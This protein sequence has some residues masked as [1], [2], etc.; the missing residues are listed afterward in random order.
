MTTEVDG[1][2]EILVEL[3]ETKYDALIEGNNRCRSIAD[4]KRLDSLEKS[5]RQDLS[6]LEG[7]LDAWAKNLDTENVRGRLLI[8]SQQLKDISDVFEI[9]TLVRGC[10]DSP[11]LVLEAAE[12]AKQLVISNEDGMLLVLLKNIAD[13][14]WEVNDHLRSVINHQT[15]LANCYSARVLMHKLVAT[16]LSANQTVDEPQFQSINSVDISQ[17]YL[18]S[19]SSVHSSSGDGA[20][21][22]FRNHVTT[23]LDRISRYQ[24]LCQNTSQYRTASGSTTKTVRQHTAA[25]LGHQVSPCLRKSADKSATQPGSIPLGSSSQVSGDYRA[26]MAEQYVAST[27]SSLEVQ[28]FA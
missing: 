24:A 25:W 27:R 14:M 16:L 3:L 20:V 9:P 6:Q 22:D 19:P 1:V 4:D 8:P 15:P 28:K 18:S 2:E 23:C 7:E 12:F 26:A 10:L 11:E 17:S 13:G 21:D 5:L